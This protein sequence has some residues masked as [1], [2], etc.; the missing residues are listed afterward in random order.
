MKLMAV[1]TLIMNIVMSK[2]DLRILAKVWMF[3]S[4]L[5]RRPPCRVPAGKDHGYDWPSSLW[6]YHHYGLLII[7]HHNLSSDTQSKRN[8]EIIV[9]RKYFRF[10][11]RWSSMIYFL[12]NSTSS[13]QSSSSWGSEELAGAIVVQSTSCPKIIH[14]LSSS[15]VCQNPQFLHSSTWEL[16]TGERLHE[17]PLEIPEPDDKKFRISFLNMRYS[18]MEHL[19]GNT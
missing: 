14:N 11:H 2:Q 7:I 15:N 13:P 16:S 8:D 9:F 18:G 5:G 17:P 4:L 6:P 1:L 3:E 10:H 12:S 19:V